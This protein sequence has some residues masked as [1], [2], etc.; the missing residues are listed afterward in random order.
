MKLA[1]DRTVLGVP[2]SRW[3][4]LTAVIL[5]LLLVAALI[6]NQLNIEWNIESLRALVQSLGTWGPLSYIGILVFRFLFLIPSSLLLIA[7]GILFEPIEGAIYA[8]LGLFGSA[9]WKYGL[10]S[11]VGTQLALSQLPRNLQTWIHQFARRKTSVWA[12]GGI[13]AYPFIPK[14]LFQFGAILSG[15]GLVAY[16]MA[17]LT[18]SF[19][20][21]GIFAWFGQALYSSVSLVQITLSLVLLLAGPMCIP[22][23]RH[24]MLAP[25]SQAKS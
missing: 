19:I 7:A 2:M 4:L 16:L 12:L 23:W 17:V 15:M 14:H 20:R 21:A 22:T 8:G 6:R 18:G 24:W 11:I 5:A 10:V 3:L 13:C 9:V 25:L 1:L